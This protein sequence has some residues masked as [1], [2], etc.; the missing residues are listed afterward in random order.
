MNFM[1]ARPPAFKADELNL[2]STP[3][4]VTGVS[5]ALRATGRRVRAVIPGRR[6]GV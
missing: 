5:R 4:D 6:T 1:T 3:R 2:Y